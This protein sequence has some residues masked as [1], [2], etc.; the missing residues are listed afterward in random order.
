MFETLLSSLKLNRTQ[1]DKING[2]ENYLLQICRRFANDTSIKQK[3]LNCLLEPEQEYLLQND[4]ITKEHVFAAL[5]RKKMP[6]DKQNIADNDGLLPIHYAALIGS[7]NYTTWIPDDVKNNFLNTSLVTEGPYAVTTGAWWLSSTFDSNERLQEYFRQYP[8]QLCS[9]NFYAAPKAGPFTDIS[10][11]SLLVRKYGR[12]SLASLPDEVFLNIDWSRKIKTPEWKDGYFKCDE[13]LSAAWYLSRGFH[14]H[15]CRLFKLPKEKL[16]ELDWNEKPSNNKQHSLIYNILDIERARYLVTK[17]PPEII[18]SI[19]WCQGLPRTDSLIAIMARGSTINDVKDYFKYLL[20]SLSLETLKNLYRS[21]ADND[22]AYQ[23]ICKEL[24]NKILTDDPEYLLYRMPDKLSL[25]HLV[26]LINNANTSSKINKKVNEHFGRL[27]SINFFDTGSSGDTW[28]RFTKAIIEHIPSPKKH[29]SDICFKATNQDTTINELLN[30]DKLFRSG[31]KFLRFQGRTILLQDNNQNILAIK[32]RKQK[33]NI[34]ELF[35]EYHTTKILNEQVDTLKLSCHFHQPCGVFKLDESLTNIIAK[36]TSQENRVITE[37]SVLEN[38]INSFKEL[39]GN[40]S[41]YACYIYRV[42]RVAEDYF[43][44]LHDIKFSDQ[45]FNSACDKSIPTLII[46]ATVHILYSQLGDI[47]HNN[48]GAASS[49]SDAGRYIVLANLLSPMALAGNPLGSGRLTNWKGAVEYPNVRGPSLPLA[50]CGDWISF[51]DILKDGCFCKQ[52][53]RP[54]Q[55]HY[56]DKVGNYLLLNLLAEYQYIFF[57]IAGRRGSALTEKAK[58]EGKDN[59]FI[60]QIWQSLAD[61][62]LMNAAIAISI[63]THDSRENSYC[64]LVSVINPTRLA[65]QMQF[66]MSKEYIPCIEQ[67]NIPKEIYGDDVQVFV[68]LERFRY[69]T[70]NHDMGFSIDRGKNEDLGPVNGQEP[71]K[72]YNKLLYFMCNKI[73]SEYHTQQLNLSALKKISRE[74]DVKNIRELSRELFKHLDERRYARIQATINEL[75]LKNKNLSQQEKSELNEE[76]LSYKRKY[77]ALTIQGLW[78]KK[79]QLNYSH[80]ILYSYSSHT[81]KN[82]V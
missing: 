41:D 26:Y 56:G 20:N 61:R 46:L 63:L 18:N 82:F 70:F 1:Q 34:Q 15:Y 53:F 42:D 44:Y 51:N 59:D 2:V 12:D 79:K 71:I 75:L 10:V 40:K 80:S 27:Q 66:F 78:K 76:K 13:S 32:V 57:L 72:E 54:A 81:N 68:D 31:W 28:W 21:L 48:E 14:K 36:L 24:E 17:L 47:F 50:D 6:E 55:D 69:K 73:V 11:L 52:Y 16:C 65:R 64:Y 29:E 74:K 67:N 25:S 22:R 37:A 35:K 5:G 43:T 3:L 58:N 39:I 23:F 4:G 9:L 30:F 8:E 77:A 38:E 60:K 7:E 33:E 45:D 49:R 19:D 62:V